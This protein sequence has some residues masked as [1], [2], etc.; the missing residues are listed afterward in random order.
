MRV[1]EAD[2]DVHVL[3]VKNGL[4]IKHSSSILAGYKDVEMNLQIV[5]AKTRIAGIDSH[6]CEI[7]QIYIPVAELKILYFVNN[8]LSLSG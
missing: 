6:V 5:S 4:D 2:C 3:R 8:V 1:I 7:Q